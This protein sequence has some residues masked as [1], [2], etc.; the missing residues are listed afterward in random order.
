MG[1]YTTTSPPSL[2]L[3]DLVPPSWSADAPLPRWDLAVPLAPPL[4]TMSH[5]T[6]CL[7]SELRD[8]PQPLH[9]PTTA[10]ATPDRR[11]PPFD[12]R[13][14]ANAAA[15]HPLR[16]RMLGLLEGESNHQTPCPVPPHTAPMLEP[17]PGTRLV[18]RLDA[19]GRAV[20]GLPHTVTVRACAWPRAMA[21]TTWADFGRGRAPW[22]GR[23][24]IVA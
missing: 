1:C 6:V 24:P 19:G 13:C 2:S 23:G 8:S 20:V 14:R 11:Q 21:S 22:R 15:P 4:S 9:S 12:A 17:P 16:R 5:R 18:A 7:P 10:G 3:L